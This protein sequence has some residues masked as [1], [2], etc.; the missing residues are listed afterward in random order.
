MQRCA[1]CEGGGAQ[2]G[3]WC[4]SV[5]DAYSNVSI[6]FSDYSEYFFRVVYF[7]VRINR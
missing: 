7:E 6:E 4:V 3:G 5:G 2:S 1:E